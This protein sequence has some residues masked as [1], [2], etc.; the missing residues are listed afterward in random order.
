MQTDAI[1][2]GVGP[3]WAAWVTRSP[4]L[5]F[6]DTALRGSGQVIFMD[7]PLTGALNFVALFWGV[8]AGGTTLAVAIGAM[9]GTL[10]A[11]AV[12]Y[13]LR[14]DRD[15]LR[16]GLYGFNGMLVG[17]GIPTFLGNTPLMWAVLVF[18][19]AASTVI[20][21]AVN[22]VVGKWNTPGLTF[23]F[24]LT[25]WLVVLMAYRFPELRVI[26]MSSPA[27]HF[28]VAGEVFGLHDFVHASLVSVA[29]VYFVDNPVSGAIFLLALVV[30]SRW[31]AGLAAVG[32]MAA[33]ACALA[34]GADT[35]VISH[36]LWGYS[37]A[38]T[39][40]AVGCVYMKT[41]VGTLVYCAIATLFTILV[42]GAMA[43]LAPKLGIP[44]LTFPFILTTWLFLIARYRLGAGSSG[45]G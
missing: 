40:P 19:C 44:A 36:G 26:G 3:G 4:F 34:M 43:T 38:L 31:C 42:Q 33:V 20:T 25:T 17:V 1:Q 39:A 29:Q 13:G 15:I 9:L 14:V 2:K 27:P 22:N 6:L 41:N 8:H 5:E 16:K 32:A 24:V 45:A 10:V 21:L 12:A 37:A 35:G 28:G 11:T 23:P 30:E 7:N 18:A